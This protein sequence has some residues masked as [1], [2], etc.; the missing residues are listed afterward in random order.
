MLGSET[1]LSEFD[2]EDLLDDEDDEDIEFNYLND[3]DFGCL[4]NPEGKFKTIWDHLHILFMLY[5]LIATPYKFSFVEEDESIL[6]NFSEFAVD[7]F[8]LCDIVL[9]FF[10]PLYVNFELITSAKTIAFIYL[11]FWFWIDLVSIF[12]FDFIFS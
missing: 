7:C 1:Q 6:W 4:I 10:T 8:F 9:T 5:V 12:P 3:E 11:K 2:D